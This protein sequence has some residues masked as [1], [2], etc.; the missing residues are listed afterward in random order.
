MH[1]HNPEPIERVEPEE[2]DEDEDNE[3]SSGT[4]MHRDMLRTAVVVPLLLTV[5][6]ESDYEGH[7]KATFLP[8]HTLFDQKNF[9]SL[10]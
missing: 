9:L 2:E 6:P 1:P 4:I 10:R 3:A 5:V 8:I 7:P